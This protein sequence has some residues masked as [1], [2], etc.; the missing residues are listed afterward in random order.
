MLRLKVTRTSDSKVMVDGL[1]TN[2]EEV[3]KSLANPVNIQRWGGVN[4]FTYSVVD[5]TKEVEL[6]QD[7]ARR[8]KKVAHGQKCLD[9]IGARMERKLETNALTSD[10]ILAF[11]DSDAFL[12]IERLLSWGYFGPAKLLISTVDSTVY[13]QNEKLELIAFIDTFVPE[14]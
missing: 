3:N 12:K 10:Q 2:Q 6:S 4:G 14:A 11:F 7:I 13:T 8:A 9:I 5:A 1:Y